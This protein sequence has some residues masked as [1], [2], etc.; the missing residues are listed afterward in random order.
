MAINRQDYQYIR[1]TIPGQQNKISDGSLGIGSKVTNLLL[2]INE[3]N[4]YNPDYADYYGE[5]SENNNSKKWKPHGSSTSETIL[6]GFLSNAVT[7]E[8]NTTYVLQVIGAT[9]PKNTTLPSNQIIVDGNS[10]NFNQYVFFSSGE[11]VCSLNIYGL[12]FGYKILGLNESLEQIQLRSFISPVQGKVYLFK[13]DTPW[14]V[15]KEGVIVGLSDATLQV[16]ENG[17]D[18][19]PATF[20]FNEAKQLFSTTAPRIYDNG[21][22]KIFIPLPDIS[23]RNKTIM[24]TVWKHYS[25]WNLLSDEDKNKIRLIACRDFLVDSTRDYQSGDSEHVET[26]R[27]GIIRT[28]QKTKSSEKSPLNIDLTLF[29]Y[30]KKK[31]AIQIS[32]AT[33]NLTATSKS[34]E[35]TWEKDKENFIAVNETVNY[36]LDLFS[37]FGYNYDYCHNNDIFKTEEGEEAAYKYTSIC[38]AWGVVTTNEQG[39]EIIDIISEYSYPIILDRNAVS[40]SWDDE[41]QKYKIKSEDCTIREQRDTNYQQTAIYIIKK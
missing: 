39:D 36:S 33:L 4:V 21:A 14:I 19:L 37:L 17:N 27:R 11:G 3:N 10:I 40:V 29:P 9:Q 6:R 24:S 16:L 34:I 38:F 35:F 25:N 8:P 23:V 20:T 7:L 5:L 13:T 30:E 26:R 18:P 1:N 31:V 12:S 2:E 15:N 32:P 22:S 41:K 28:L